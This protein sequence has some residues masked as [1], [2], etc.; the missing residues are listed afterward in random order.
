MSF[1]SIVNG[2]ISD[3]K[4][5]F[6][7]AIESGTYTPELSYRPLIDKFLRAVIANIDDD[8]VCVSE[9]NN[10]GS[11]GRPDWRFHNRSSLG[12][13]GYIEA[14]KIRI[15]ASLNI[16]DYEEQIEKY[17]LLEHNLLLTDG[18]DFIFFYPN[19]KENRVVSLIPKPVRKWCLSEENKLLENEFRK[20][21][22]TPKSRWVN[23][24]T[25]I[26]DIA[27]RAI[28][29]SNSIIE[30]C[31][32]NELVAFE[33]EITL[34]KLLKEMK[35]LLAEHYDSTLSINDNFADYITQVLLFGL[36]YSHRVTYKKGDTPTERLNKI[37]A[38]FSNF[39]TQN[40]NE[41]LA[42]FKGIIRYLGSELS[43]G[44][45]RI[46]SW[47]QDAILYLSYINLTE[48][49]LAIPDYHNLFERFLS[50]YKPM[51]RFDYGA[52]YTP[53]SLAKYLVRFCEGLIENSSKIPVNKCSKCTIVDPC[54]GTG[55]FLEELISREGILR[56]I[57][58]DVI[59]YEILPAPYALAN[60]RIS[61][62][63]GGASKVKIFLTDTLSDSVNKGVFPQETCEKISFIIREQEQVYEYSNNDIELILCN[64]PVSDSYDYRQKSKHDYVNELMEDFRPPNKYRTS[65]SNIQK[66]VRNS[67]MYFLRWAI[68][69]LE[70]KD[71]AILGLILPSSFI[72]NVSYKYARSYLSNHFDNLWVLKFD[73]DLRSKTRS[74]NI[75][76]TQQ[77]R[78]VVVAEKGL[79]DKKIKELKYRCISS[80]CKEEKERFF[81]KSDFFDFEQ[82]CYQL[83]LFQDDFAPM[84]KAKI[85]ESETTD[86]TM[87]EYSESCW[88]I[89]DNS[90]RYQ[91]VF[92]RS[93]SGV[94][95]GATGL[96][97][98]ADEKILKRRFF[99]LTS[100]DN[101]EE[102]YNSILDKQSTPKRP[103]I[104]KVKVIRKLLE[105]SNF[106][107]DDIKEYPIQKY[108]YRPFIETYAFLDHQ[109]LK[110]MQREGGGGTRPRPELIKLF[111]LNEP[112]VAFAV[113][114]NIKE[115]NKSLDRF[116]SFCWETPDNDLTR[117]GNGTVLSNKYPEYK[118]KDNSNLEILSNINEALLKH[119]GDSSQNI[120]K[121][122]LS[123]IITYYSYAVMCSNVYLKRYHGQLFHMNSNIQDIRIPVFKDFEIIK[124]ISDIGKDMALL[125]KDTE[126]EISTFD[127]GI[128]VEIEPFELLRV[129]FK[130]SENKLELITS[131]KNQILDVSKEVLNFSVS[132]HNVL[133][134]WLELRVTKNLHRKFNKNDLKDL[135]C[136]I[137]RI[138]S[139]LE[140]VEDL[141]EIVQDALNEQE[142]LVPEKKQ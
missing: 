129:K 135:L 80:Y 118:S 107:R 59:G 114:R 71:T 134:K 44:L 2:Y 86:K 94:K 28:P 142:L 18:L 99:N 22:S 60:Y 52:F 29:L 24:H 12:V 31:N 62:I 100:N 139:Q 8:I 7:H 102:I 89:F 64:P 101:I 70:S 113:S 97:T 77:G 109:V 79:S 25:I 117:R 141:D 14:K 132:G 72:E 81:E 126:I 105:S 27:K 56:K 90:S 125:E 20:F 13:Y 83:E 119:F 88:K 122:K 103:N 69:K 68:K 58:T 115:Q 41:R 137:V 116:V 96:L 84:L 49:Q 128:D 140:L 93:C 43:D 82:S 33:D 85:Y 92:Q 39:V 26:E 127:F 123:E 21:F 55:T 108:S 50:I 3:L 121:S 30:T 120:S 73:K 19:S 34:L 130:P 78:V 67:F 53:R 91:C 1:N 112:P 45:G 10:Q 104:D 131:E 38:Y 6:D 42:P 11:F 98:H 65:R 5:E 47:Y 54:C 66:Q 61:M 75:F 32:I 17:K 9:P 138:K 106:N 37:Q 15:D 23:E 48:E 136:L 16:N 95:L 35:D 36:I 133:S 124:A 87:Q 51:V 63:K 76:N 57:T 74:Q 111:S 40:D 46:G 110:K 4:S